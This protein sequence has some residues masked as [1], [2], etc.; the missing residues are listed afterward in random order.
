MTLNINNGEKLFS[1]FNSGRVVVNLLYL[2]LTVNANA[3]LAVSPLRTLI[4]LFINLQLT[5][6]HQVRLFV[7]NE[8]ETKY[9]RC[10]LAFRPY[11]PANPT[12]QISSIRCL[13]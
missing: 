12:S 5:R 13:W 11:H 7:I 8:S 9:I 1:I 4:F 2:R 6:L 10:H 3:G